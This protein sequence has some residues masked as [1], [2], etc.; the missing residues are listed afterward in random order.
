[1]CSSDLKGK[2]VSRTE[3]AIL[4]DWMSEATERQPASD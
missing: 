3:A 2:E 4:D 1:V